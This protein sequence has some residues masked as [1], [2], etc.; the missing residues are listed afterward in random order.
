[1][2]VRE[3]D[4]PVLMGEGALTFCDLGLQ[5]GDML[6]GVMGFL[7]LVGLG[8]AGPSEASRGSWFSASTVKHQE[9]LR[10]RWPRVRGSLGDAGVLGGPC[11]LKPSLGPL[12]V[13]RPPPSRSTPSLFVVREVNVRGVCCPAGWFR[14]ESAEE[15][16]K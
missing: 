1:M 12:A 6:P 10:T 14:G 7:A 8:L 2:K 5:R 9:C 3:R 4:T 15:V 11:L 16:R 13:T